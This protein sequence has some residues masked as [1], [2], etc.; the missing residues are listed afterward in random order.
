MPIVCQLL[1]N[2]NTCE[3]SNCDILDWQSYQSCYSSECPYT[4]C[5]GAAADVKVIG[6]VCST[7]GTPVLIDIEGNGFQLTDLQGGVVFS[8]NGVSPVRTSWIAVGSD[9]SFL[10]KDRNGNGLCD[11]GTELFSN[12]SPQS[13]SFSPNGFR[14]L[15]LEDTNS[16]GK[17]SGAELDDL[18]LWN[19]ANHNGVSESIEVFSL[20]SVKL[21][22]L[23]TR[24][25][26]SRR[27]DQF[28]NWL[29]YRANGKMDGA[30]FKCTTF[31]S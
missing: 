13:A 25:T 21:T 18:L 16:D 24:Y 14:T 23:D 2:S 3:G 19:D 30:P 27:K 1:V 9:D 15:A 4:E 7:P 17:V 10:C 20:V 31:S 8:Y 29:R 28:D 22:S 11:D 12:Y 6:P 5:Y 26:S